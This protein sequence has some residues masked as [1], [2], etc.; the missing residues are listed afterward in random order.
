[1]ENVNQDAM[2]HQ[3]RTYQ[4]DTG[5]PMQIPD[6]QDMLSEQVSD[7]ENM[8]PDDGAHGSAESVGNNDGNLPDPER[9]ELA[10]ATLIKEND[11]MGDDGDLAMP[12]ADD[13]LL[14]E[15]DAGV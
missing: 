10:E 15:E 11:A 1:M 12:E 4:S 13:S 14:A 2:M 8:V 3:P 5:G 7:S 6:Q 9:I